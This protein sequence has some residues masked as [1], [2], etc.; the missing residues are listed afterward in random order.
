LDTLISIIVIAHNRKRYLP[1][2]F[3]NLENQTLNKN[4]YEVIVVKNFEDI[5]S[6]NIIKKNDWKNIVTNVV[7]V[8]GKY[9]IGLNEAKGNIIT[10]LEDDDQY[11]SNRLE[12]VVNKFNINKNLI[13]L[14][15]GY[16]EINSSNRTVRVIPKVHADL[17]ISNKIKKSW[18]YRYLIAKP[19]YR[20]YEG[21]A[22]SSCISI[23][24]FIKNELISFLK[25]YY[26]TGFC[27]ICSCIKT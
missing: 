1:Y 26:I 12:I 14:H 24:K 15:N 11:K 3:E 5:I 27:N 21:N 20:V 23:K 7:P 18:N 6:D 25:K 16:I 19:I 8:S 22:Y 2:V 4:K 17:Y 13:Y 9:I 10:V